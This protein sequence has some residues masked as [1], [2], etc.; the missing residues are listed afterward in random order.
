METKRIEIIKVAELA[1]LWKENPELA[2]IDVRTAGEYESVHAQ[3]V[4]LHP[5]QEFDAVKF[6]SEHGSKDRPVYIFCKSG[7]RSTQA[8]EKLIEA[9]C[10][11]PVVVE[12]GTDAWI[13]ADLPVE[14]RGRKVLPLDRQMRTVAGAFIFLGSLLTL[15]VSPT[16]VWIPLFMGGGLVFSGIT[17]ICPM[18]NVIA[19]MPWN[20]ASGRTCCSGR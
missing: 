11:K 17:G 20:Q 14:H 8:A 4:K 13:A 15:T 19:K 5:L 9:G 16:F 3:G 12:G 1:K 18:T 7:V 6:V 10:T 2:V